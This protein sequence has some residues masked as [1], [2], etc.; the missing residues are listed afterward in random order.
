MEDGRT[1]LPPPSYRAERRRSRVG[2]VRETLADVRTTRVVPVVPA[3]RDLTTATPG[4]E[5]F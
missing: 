4:F 2:V 1:C 5:E 3:D